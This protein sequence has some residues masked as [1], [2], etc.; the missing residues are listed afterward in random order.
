MPCSLLLN[1]EAS[2]GASGASEVSRCRN[3]WTDLCA[4]G[5]NPSAL[6]CPTDRDGLR[7]YR[8]VMQDI[9]VISVAIFL[10]YWAGRSLV[11]LVSETQDKMARVYYPEL[12]IV[13]S[14]VKIK[15]P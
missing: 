8:V 1:A 9:F 5:S 11:H 2:T 7:H 6:D 3:V 12:N 14:R 15:L 13:P 10:S 4:G